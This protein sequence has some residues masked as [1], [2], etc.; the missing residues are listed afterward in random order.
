MAN[1]VVQSDLVNDF[2]YFAKYDVYNTTWN[3]KND[4][5]IRFSGIGVKAG[6]KLSPFKP[7]PSCKDTIIAQHPG[8][9]TPSC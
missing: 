6:D 4:A 7:S 2:M 5:A 9:S 1:K 3:S 8:Y